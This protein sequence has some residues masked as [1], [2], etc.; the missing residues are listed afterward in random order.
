MLSSDVNNNIC[1]LIRCLFDII[2]MTVYQN[3]FTQT[4]AH[5]L[6]KGEAVID[7]ACKHKHYSYE[8]R[9]TYRDL[10]VTYQRLKLK[11]NHSVFSSSVAELI[12][13]FLH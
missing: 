5:S 10:S 1:S 7:G 9:T 4:A 8:V 6:T 11:V 12:C 3:A 13:S 2:V